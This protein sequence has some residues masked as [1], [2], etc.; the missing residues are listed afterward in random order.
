MMALEREM[1]LVDRRYSEYTVSTV[2]CKPDSS[3]TDIA[4]ITL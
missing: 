2:F 3:K 4:Y 1:D